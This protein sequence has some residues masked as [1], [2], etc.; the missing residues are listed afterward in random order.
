[1][2][3]LGSIL[4]VAAL[5]A[6]GMALGNLIMPIDQAMIYLMGV[7]LV[8]AKL[9]RGPSFLYSFLSVSCFNFF[10]IPPIYSFDMYDRSYW[11][12][13]VVMLMTNVV[14]TSQASQLRHQAFVFRKREA[15]TQV[16]YALTRELAS[17]RSHQEI[18]NVAV[19]H[20]AGMFGVEAMIGLPDKGG[21][22]QAFMGSLPPENLVKETGVL[23][24]CFDNGKSA[25]HG[26]ATMPSATGLYFPL[27]ASSGTLGVL[28]VIPLT[29][30]RVF[31][32]E[33]LSSLETCASLLA[34][35]LERANSAEA[36]EIS[37]IE[38][39]SEKLRAMLLSSVSHDLR[40]P[41]A[42]ITGAS[43]TIAADD[44]DLSRDTLRDLGRSINKEAERLS[45]LV[46]N[47]LEVTRLESGTVQLN[48]QPYFIEELIGSALSALAP[49]LLTHTVIPQSD[50]NLPLVF[51]DGVLIE[52][53]LIN[54]LEN[55]AH[56]TPQGSTI[57]ISAAR[58][59][60]NVKVS[61]ADN[62]PGIVPGNE[63]KIFDKFYSLSRN[64]AAKG[65][66]LGL[67]ICASIVRAHNGEIKAE[68]LPESGACFSFTLP[69]T[70]DA[71]KEANDAP[72]A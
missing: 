54:L 43:S 53:L 2:F 26:T 69:V 16:F 32:N 15:D 35:A 39:E 30:D 36:V 71:G 13:L 50:E 19:R 55:A 52:Q 5:T 62:G 20:I 70:D 68:N 67:S 9:G 48:K 25:G 63:K 22:M 61:V 18:A 3:Y 4:A 60:A 33:E 8:S 51:V 21:Q 1:M 34:S 56:Y 42:S 64:D 27:I 57:R 23:Q 10:F 40:T 65:T 49:V 28:C 46:T 7:I 12:T 66:G 59:G 37:K 14:I 29:P 45:R 11:L 31:S 17:A 58:N 38:V 24:W 47:L 44:N 72:N 41:L 6:V